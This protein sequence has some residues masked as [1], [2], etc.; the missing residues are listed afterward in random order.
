MTNTFRRGLFDI[1]PES[2]VLVDRGIA[3]EGS[4]LCG[5]AA[6]ISWVEADNDNNRYSVSSLS[7]IRIRMKCRDD[8]NL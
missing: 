2:R 5:M 1:R 4:N 3:Q 7:L 6:L 8:H